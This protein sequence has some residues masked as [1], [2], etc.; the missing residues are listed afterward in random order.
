MGEECGMREPVLT[1]PSHV[2]FCSAEHLGQA[3]RTKYIFDIVI[4]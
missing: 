3:T 1:Y 4:K 2:C